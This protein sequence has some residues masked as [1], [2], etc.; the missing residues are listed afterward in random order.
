MSDF[1]QEETIQAAVATAIT[2]KA[3]ISFFTLVFFSNPKVVGKFEK[4]KPV[5]FY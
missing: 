5:R 3:V 2:A 1:L 4:Q